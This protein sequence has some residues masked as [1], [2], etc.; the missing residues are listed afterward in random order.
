M[1]YSPT[2]KREWTRHTASACN[3]PLD[4]ITRSR[5][6][7]S[8][9]IFDDYPSRRRGRSGL[10]LVSPLQIAIR[11]ARVPTSCPWS[12][13]PVVLQT[14]ESHFA[15]KSSPS[16]KQKAKYSTQAI[17]SSSS[18]PAKPSFNH[19]AEHMLLSTCL[20]PF[21]SFSSP[22]FLCYTY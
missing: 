15:P 19:L 2:S 14:P 6:L 9:L 1:H 8:P 16:T 18:R 4:N 7:P 3:A 13:C 20:S 5:K 22:C 21:L 17:R 10:S 11:F 12:P